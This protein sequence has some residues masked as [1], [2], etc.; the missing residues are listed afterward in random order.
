VEVLVALLLGLLVLHLTL[1]TVAT[2]RTGQASWAERSERLATLRIARA[3]VRAD[4][5]AGLE[6]RDWLVSRPDSVRLR[7]FVGR[8]LPCAPVDRRSEVVVAW[9]GRRRPDPRRDSLLVL[10]AAGVWQSVDLVSAVPTVGVCPGAVRASSELWRTTL[11]P[12]TRPEIAVLFTSGSYH[13]SGGALRYR[14]GRAGRQP[15]TPGVLTPRSGLSGSGRDVRLDLEGTNGW[16][17][18]GSLAYGGRRAR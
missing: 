1:R 15:L 18:D 14:R 11:A 3:L 8:G 16:T 4:L 7:S 2:A 6:G 12:G 10:D 5:R 17:W 13:V 9:E